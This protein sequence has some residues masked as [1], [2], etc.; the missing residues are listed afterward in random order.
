MWWSH[1]SQN[2]AGRPAGGL[3]ATGRWLCNLQCQHW[4][5]GVETLTF[6]RWQLMDPGCKQTGRDRYVLPW[7]VVLGVAIKAAEN[8]CC[9]CMLYIH[10]SAQATAKGTLTHLCPSQRLQVQVVGRA[11]GAGVS[12]TT[13][14]GMTSSSGTDAC[15]C[16]E[17]VWHDSRVPGIH[18][19]RARLGCTYMFTHQN[20]RRATAGMQRHHPDIGQADAY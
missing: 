15:G 13:A 14:A 8:A 18:A 3:T 5:S 10:A 2:R 6:C 7:T 19:A 9:T 4:V 17:H 16:A 1:G 11:L 12:C 20:V